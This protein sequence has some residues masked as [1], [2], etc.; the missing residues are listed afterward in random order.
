M[1]WITL[2]VKYWRYAVALV[3][4]LVAMLVVG[5]CVH[6]YGKYHYE[7]G[8]IAGVASMREEVD[9]ANAAIAKM[10]REAFKTAAKHAEQMAQA[11]QDY[12][13]LKAQ[14]EQKEKVQYVEVQKIVE[15]PVYH[16]EC[17][18]TSGL[19]ELNRAIKGK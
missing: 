8:K 5:Y 16:I 12:Q 9:K 10:D 18:D 7:R 4:M 6:Q 13:T 15:K 17:L 3:A 11:S 1:T 19:S 2:N 14:R